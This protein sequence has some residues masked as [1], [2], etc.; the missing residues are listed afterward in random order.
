MKNLRLLTTISFISVFVFLMLASPA[1]SGTYTFSPF[2]SDL[3]DLDHSYYYIWGIN[4]NLP[5]GET[6]TGAALTYKNI[7]DWTPET[8][9]TLYTHLLNS[10]QTGVHWWWDG[11]GGGD[12]FGSLP[13]WQ[14]YKLGEWHDDGGGSPSN[15]DLVY[16]I[17]DNY[18]SWLSDG[19]FGFGIDP[20]CHYYNS[21][22]TFEIN[23]TTEAPEPAT[24]L[25]LGSG[26]IGLAG[27]ARRRLSKK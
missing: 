7:Y 2:P 5:S 15:F 23:T 1:R 9:D 20:D 4:W 11:E 17:P 10:A 24:L 16:T 26:L 13:I 19:D 18:F 21:G 25:L 3:G 8:Y 6:I 12:N 14:G 22:I 27:L